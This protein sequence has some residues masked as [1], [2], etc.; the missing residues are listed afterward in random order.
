[1]HRQALLFSRMLKR[2]FS[3]GGSRRK[4]A[5][6]G[7]GK[8][9]E[10]KE[11]EDA[12][13]TPATAPL[14]YGYDGAGAGGGN[15]AGGV[16]R[17][18]SDQ[19]MGSEGY[20]DAQELYADNFKLRREQARLREELA[21][22]KFQEAKLAAELEEASDERAKLE[23]RLMGFVDHLH[24]RDV[25]LARLAEEKAEAEALLQAL[26][27]YHEQEQEQQAQERRQQQQQRR[28]RPGGPPIHGRLL[29]A[30]CV[31]AAPGVAVLLLLLLAAAAVPAADHRLLGGL[32]GLLF[33][34]RSAFW[35]NRVSG[36]LALAPGGGALQ[37]GEYLRSCRPRFGLAVLGG[38][39]GPSR[40]AA[41]APPHVLHLGH[42]GNLVLYRGH[43]PVN[44]GGAVWATGALSSYQMV[45]GAGGGGSY[46]A[47]VDARG[48]LRVVKEEAGKE[49]VVFSRPLSR[50][51]TDLVR[52]GMVEGSRR[53]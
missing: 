24:D 12:L 29:Y 22:K 7:G 38:C 42:D 30:L 9:Q 4:A 45:G 46:R 2:L 35:Q 11:E 37:Q 40:T 27:D 8:H 13:R 50:L 33:S 43:S 32:G 18:R 3:G 5:G 34:P 44:H 26:A 28:G 39:G 15:G 52:L 36:L 14:D 47:L 53:R 17:G 25:K 20:F 23:E 6:G 51:P 16:P 19:S 31:A 1:M 48:E 49:S 10:T 21:K 41:A